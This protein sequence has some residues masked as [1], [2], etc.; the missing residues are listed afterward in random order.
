MTLGERIAA[1]RNSQK[2][3]QGDLAEKLNVSR[4]S[5]SKW[6]TNTSIP[7]LDKLVLLSDLFGITLDELVK[8]ETVPEPAEAPAPEAE[9][10]PEEREARNSGSTRKIIGTILLCFGVLIWLLITLLGDALFGLL[11][12]SP[13]LLCGAICLIVRRNTGLWC[14][15]A[16][17]AAADLYLRTATGIN[18]RLTRLT[19]LYEPSMNY[20]R[21]AVAWLE[22]LYL[23]V[24][25]AVT[26]LRFRKKPLALT[27]RGKWLYGAG[28]VA[29]A[30]LFLPF[31]L[32]PLSGLTGIFYQLLDWT[33]VGLL[34]A[35][36]SVALRLRRGRKT[37]GKT[38]S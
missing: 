32:D 1:L 11:F 19:L 23:I 2:L 15:W 27:R 20:A 4:Q 13:F 28:W 34:T 29:F 14:A 12:G 3:S 33:R 24:M 38:A 7:E 10:A 6:E 26:V 21:L 30:A 25:V 35:L 16:V 18:W 31:P 22:E 9:K 36:V 17:F 37:A 8:G 5:V